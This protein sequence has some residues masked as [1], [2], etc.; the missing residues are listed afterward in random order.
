LCRWSWRSRA[1]PFF[2]GE[3]DGTA[4]GR[5]H[6]AHLAQRTRQV[7][8]EHHTE[9]AG[10]AVEAGVGE[11]KLVDVCLLKANV[12]EAALAGP[13]LADLQWFGRNVRADN[14]A[15]ILEQRCDGNRGLARAAGSIEHTHSG[16]DMRFAHDRLGHGAS[17]G[18]GLGTPAL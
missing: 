6:A 13:L 4:A 17:H 10:D 8:E 9:P 12:G 15:R 2:P 11:G 18:S 14:A 1:G 5:Q 16:L 3:Q 7:G